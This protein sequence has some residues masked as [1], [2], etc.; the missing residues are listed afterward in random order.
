MA[1]GETRVVRLEYT[2]PPNA[3]LK[4]RYTLTL[5]KEP[6]A[7]AMPVRVRVAMPGKN[8]ADFSL[9]LNRNQK[10]S[11]EADSS[12]GWVVAGA[13]GA[14]VLIIGGVRLMRRKSSVA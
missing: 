9:M 11:V 2:E 1:R 12:L 5:E 10:I 6:G 4:S 3:Q 8:A 14:S 13:F 7:P